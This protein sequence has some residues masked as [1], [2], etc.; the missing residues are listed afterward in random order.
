MKKLRLAFAALSVASLPLSAHALPLVGVDVLGGANLNISTYNS[1][2][3]PSTKGGMSYA[4]GAGA[5][6]G[7]ISAR[8]IYNSLAAESSGTTTSSKWLQVPIHFVTGI[9]GSSFGFGGFF[10]SSLES[11]GGSNYGASAGLK[12]G[13]PMTGLSFQGI[14]NYGL[15]DLGVD[16]RQ[17]SIL[18]LVGIG[19]L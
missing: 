2:G 1:S 6:L 17:S 12:I 9:A 16:H 3:G 5:E 11:G 7:P 19:L 18:F 10:E 8:V 14:A 4:A 13:V 15:K